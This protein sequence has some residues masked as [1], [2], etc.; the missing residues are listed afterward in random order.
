MIVRYLY[1]KKNHY[2]P[3][4]DDENALRSEVPY[5]SVIDALL[6]LAQYTRSNITFS[7]NLLAKYSSAPTKRH[8]GMV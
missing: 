5:L 4:E 8:S 1:I 7:V 6:Y 2:R 3:K